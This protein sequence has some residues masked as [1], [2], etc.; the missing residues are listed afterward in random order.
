M[1][2]SFFL[3]VPNFKGIAFSFSTL[4]LMFSVGLSYMAFKMMR[5]VLSISILLRIFYCEWML[6]LVKCFFCIFCDDHMIFI[7]HFVNVVYHVDWFADVESSLYAGLNI[8]WSWYIILLMYCILFANILLGFFSS[9]F[10]R[11]IGL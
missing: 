1:W 11:D 10:I 5:Y 3:F 8:T 9:V 6:T 7:L 2:A 4:N